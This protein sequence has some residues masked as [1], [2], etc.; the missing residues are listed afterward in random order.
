MRALSISYLRR[1][2]VRMQINLLVLRHF[3]RCRKST[4]IKPLRQGKEEK[5]MKESVS[6]CSRV[7]GCFPTSQSY[8][9][10]PHSGASLCVLQEY[11]TRLKDKTRTGRE[12]HMKGSEHFYSPF[13]H[14]CSLVR[15][16]GVNLIHPACDEGSR[17]ELARSCSMCMNGVSKHGSDDST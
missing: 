4:S 1:E 16:Q 17:Y 12:Y 8:R 5:M 9:W 7:L 13:R 11:E 3:I 14:V 15:T 6:T 10:L 2:K